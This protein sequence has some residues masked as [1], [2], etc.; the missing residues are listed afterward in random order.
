[1]Q[2][3]GSPVELFA[4]SLLKPSVS[5]LITIFSCHLP[6]FSTLGEMDRPSTTQIL[7]KLNCIWYTSCPVRNIVQNNKYNKYFSFYLL[8]LLKTSYVGGLYLHA[9]LPFHCQH[10]SKLWKLVF[11][12]ISNKETMEV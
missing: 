12:G 4:G 5:V 2:L 8:F 1:V 11:Q 3:D 10:T 9:F 7:L 6:S